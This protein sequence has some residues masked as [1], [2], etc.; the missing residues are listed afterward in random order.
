VEVVAEDF[1]EGTTTVTVWR[2]VNGREFKVRGLIGVS[3]GGTVSGRDF[4]VPPGVVSSYRVQQFDAGGEFIAW[5]SAETVTMPPL[6]HNYQAWW[7]NPFDPSSA[8][9]VEFR[10]GDR[11]LQRPLGD[12]DVFQI[13][14][15]SVGVAI[16]NNARRGYEKLQLDC[17]TLTVEDEAKF[18]ALFGGYDDNTIPIVC[19]RSNPATRLPA[20]LFAVV[21]AAKQPL[22]LD[23]A[24]AGEHLNWAAVGD[25]VAPPAEA[26]VVT[27][28]GYDDFTAFYSDY[29]EFTA[30]YTDYR[31]AQLDYSIAGTA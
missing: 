11:T 23:P 24:D 31:E 17:V 21:Q 26:I 13:P 9:L 10:G 5:S 22:D 20:P 15:R 25:E 12:H 30:A 2:T 18:D 28:L 16:F 29:A 27:L 3:A 14:G 6:T 7:H 1:D 8:V 19:I 4:E